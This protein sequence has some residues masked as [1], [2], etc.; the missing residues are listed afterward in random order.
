[1]RAFGLARSAADKNDQTHKPALFRE[2]FLRQLEEM[3]SIAGNDDA[4]LLLGVMKNGIIAGHDRQCVAQ[5]LRI[6]FPISQ[7]ALHFVRHIVVQ[8][9]SQP[10]ASLIC[11][12][13]SASISVR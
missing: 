6:I 1:M 4:L 8:Y 3:A 13:I 5:T 10:R 2:S 12:A 7:Q 11:S 9:K